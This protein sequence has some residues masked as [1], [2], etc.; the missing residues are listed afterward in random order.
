MSL[1]RAQELFNDV[2]TVATQDL[3]NHGES[4]HDVLHDYL[5]MAEDI[6]NFV[7]EHELQSPTL[8]GHSMLVRP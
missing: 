5:S 6:E 4:P 8:I 3:R 2:H 1:C 7:G